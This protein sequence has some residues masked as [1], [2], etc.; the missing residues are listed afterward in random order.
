MSSCARRRAR[1]TEGEGGRG[2][3]DTSGRRPQNGH[4]PSDLL[5]H[6]ASHE[7]VARRNGWITERGLGS[8]HERGHHQG[9]LING[10]V[11]KHGRKPRQN[12]VIGELPDRQPPPPTVLPPNK[13]PSGKPMP[14]PT[15]VDPDPLS[16]AGD[17]ER[18]I[19]QNGLKSDGTSPNI[20]LPR[21]L[22]RKIKPH[23]GKHPPLLGG[24]VIPRPRV[25]RGEPLGSIFDQCEKLVRLDPQPSTSKRGPQ[26]R[27]TPQTST[28]VRQRAQ[29]WHEPPAEGDPASHRWQARHRGE[30]A[31]SR[32]PPQ[33]RLRRAKWPTSRRA[34][35]AL[36]RHAAK[37]AFRA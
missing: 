28:P 2:S 19:P 23:S 30:A 20:P 10:N 15:G 18:G 35:T 33:A 25:K 36:S 3:R 22:R 16:R 21:P 29:R 11:G 32:R 7:P 34:P 26:S 8:C 27:H 5:G 14:N 9:R 1:S 31:P 24:E 13:L 17:G 12:V 4:E 6:T 37:G